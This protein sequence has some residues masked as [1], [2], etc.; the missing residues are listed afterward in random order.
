[1]SNLV[2][3]SAATGWTNT[4]SLSGLSRGN[5]TL[6]ITATDAFANTGQT[7]R[8]FR[9][10]SPP[11][12][13]V[14]EPRVGTV[15]RPQFQVDASASDDDPIGT[16]INVYQGATLLA[17]GTNT[18]STVVSILG[19]DGQPVDVTFQAVDSVGQTTNI[20]RTVYVFTSTNW[21]EV[22]RVEGPI[23]DVAT[24]N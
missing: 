18:L 5:K 9:K 17:S 12:L 1:T 16:T 7:Q 8:V 22:A 6:T 20:V 13:T 3:S 24:N 19:Y 11:T 4:M 21:S 14:T 15:A 23:F 10:D 2:F